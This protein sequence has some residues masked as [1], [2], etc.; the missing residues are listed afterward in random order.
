MSED[1]IASQQNPPWPPMSGSMRNYTPWCIFHIQTEENPTGTDCGA[2]LAEG[3]MPH[4]CLFRSFDEAKKGNCEDAEIA[5]PEMSISGDSK[6]LDMMRTEDLLEIMISDI[7]SKETKV[8]AYEMVR[9]RLK[10][11]GIFGF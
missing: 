6:H 1:S 4:S 8:K 2:H 10:K 9:E 5:T 7:E 11:T 3:H